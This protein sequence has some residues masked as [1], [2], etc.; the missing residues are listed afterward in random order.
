MGTPIYNISIITGDIIV[1]WKSIQQAEKPYNL[2]E[3]LSDSFNFIFLD[4]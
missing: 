1:F 2:V 4:S 3:S